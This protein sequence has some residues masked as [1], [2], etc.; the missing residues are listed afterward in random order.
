[1]RSIVINR[2]GRKAALLRVC[3]LPVAPSLCAKIVQIHIHHIV[4][5]VK[6]NFCMRKR[7]H[8][9]TRIF[10]VKNKQA[11]GIRAIFASS[12]LPNHCANDVRK[13]PNDKTTAHKTGSFLL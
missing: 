12:K 13:L 8:V 4:A 10:N 6:K 2:T 5:N 3:S 11:I 7:L 1:M 9:K